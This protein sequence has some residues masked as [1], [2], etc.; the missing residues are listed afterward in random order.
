MK[1][2]EDFV[3]WTLLAPTLVALRHAA[4]QNDAAAIKQVLVQLV[5]GYAP[6]LETPKYI[7]TARL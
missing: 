5:Q 2:H 3:P 4:T 6:K 1:A 7:E